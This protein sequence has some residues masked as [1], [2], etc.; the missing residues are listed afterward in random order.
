MC[1][2]VDYLNFLSDYYGEKLDLFISIFEVIT[3]VEISY[4]GRPGCKSFKSTE[5]RRDSSTPSHKVRISA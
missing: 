5:I 4:F 3:I 2:I 1:I